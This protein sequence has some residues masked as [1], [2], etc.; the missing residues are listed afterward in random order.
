MKIEGAYTFPGVIER[1]FATLINPDILA[2]AIPGCERLIQFGPADADGDATFEARLRL[3]ER[4]AHYTATI[5]VH[6]TRRPTYLR[7]TITGR[8]PS[9]PVSGQGSID[10]VE[11]EQHTVVAYALTLEA[12]DLPGE[13]PA[14]TQ[15]AQ[16][17]ARATCTHIADDLYAEWESYSPA[18]GVYMMDAPNP[19]SNGALRPLHVQT[20]LGE[21]VTL[22]PD[23]NDM[24]AGSTLALLSRPWAQRALWMGAGLALGLTAIGFT[25]GIVRKLGGPEH[26]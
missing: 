12:A 21:I 20:E 2:R 1:V 11:Q 18:L 13:Q 19:S 9:G 6:A 24:G 10:L 15:A 14:A 3:G 7:L 17:I 5:T 25:L 22:T 26:H 4:R 16:L 23:T 8:G